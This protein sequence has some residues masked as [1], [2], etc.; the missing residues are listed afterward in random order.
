MG[1]SHGQ[2]GRHI[3]GQ[4]GKGKEERSKQQTSTF[5][6]LFTILLNFHTDLSL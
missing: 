2:R 6:T 1:K 5:H 3:R 4:G